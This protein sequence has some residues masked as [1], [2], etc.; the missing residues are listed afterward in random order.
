MDSMPACQHGMLHSQTSPCCMSA[1]TSTAIKMSCCHDEHAHAGSSAVA[2][3]SIAREV[4]RLVGDKGK[5][6]VVSMDNAAG[7]GGYNIASPATA[8]V[9]QPGAITGSVGARTAA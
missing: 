2:S 8:I 5:P 4:E 6:V 1:S 9:A 3:D 7:S